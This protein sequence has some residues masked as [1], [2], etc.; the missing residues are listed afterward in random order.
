MCVAKIEILMAEFENIRVEVYEKTSDD[1]Y[2]WSDLYG[3]HSDLS[4]WGAGDYHSAGHKATESDRMYPAIIKSLEEIPAIPL[5][6]LFSRS[7]QIAL[8]PVNWRSAEVIFIHKGE[9]G[10]NI[11]P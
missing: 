3:G 6:K 5:S 1:I 11:G 2:L 8:L 10:V 4:H 9:S 7:F